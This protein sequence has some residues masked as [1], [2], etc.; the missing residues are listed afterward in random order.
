MTDTLTLIWSG[1]NFKSSSLTNTDDN[2]HLIGTNMVVDW[3]DDDSEFLMRGDRFTHTY[4]SNGTYTITITG[5]SIT[6]LGDYCFYKCTGLVN[7]NIPSSVTSFGDF[8]FKG[9]SDL[10]NIDIPSS[11][12]SFNEECFANC[13]NLKNII[14]PSGVT[15][16][17][18][19]CFYNCTSLTNITIPSNVT[20]LQSHCFHNCTYLKNIIFMNLTPPTPSLETFKNIPASCK[21]YVPKGSLSAYTS[22]G[23]YP[24][25]SI[26]TYIERDM[27]EM[28]K[29]QVI[30][31]EIF[32][33]LHPIGS[34]YMSVL[35]DNPSILFGGV[36]E[37]IKDKFLLG[38]GDNYANLE[39]GG[40][41]DAVNVAHTHE[42]SAGS[43]AQSL[44]ILTDTSATKEGFA[45]A[46]YWNGEKKAVSSIST[47][48][49]DPTGANMPPYTTVYIWRRIG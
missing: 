11:V 43:N 18:T 12:T 49:S 41:A 7:I 28:E 32:N 16:L 19:G 5:D 9:C 10:I 34:I 20:T 15:K 30:A 17:D 27:I 38:C 1:Q 46:G 6:Q 48:G 2:Y 26:Y 45:V 42:F 8:C 24:S 29:A 13:T 44:N 47:A 40:N 36:W 23:Q 14:I 39:T 4:S 21:I 37:Q 31:R 33:K 35:D 3:G 25:N 22:L